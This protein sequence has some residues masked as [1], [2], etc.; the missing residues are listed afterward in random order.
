VGEA[1]ESGYGEFKFMSK[2]HPNRM[3]VPGDGDPCPRCGMAMQIYEHPQVTKHERRRPFYYSRWFRCMND[4]CRTTTVLPDRYRVWNNNIS[5]TRRLA[6]E[7]WM[8]KAQQERNMSGDLV[9]WGDKWN[10]EAA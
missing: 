4:R 3:L 6:L 9:L 1:A 10:E 2:Y 8:R 5:K 7:A